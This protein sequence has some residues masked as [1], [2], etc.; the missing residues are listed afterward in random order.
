M[1]KRKVVSGK[2]LY[3]KLKNDYN[4]LNL[5]FKRLQFENEKMKDYTE[6]LKKEIECKNRN[7]LQEQLKCNK[8]TKELD[9]KNNKLHEEQFKNNN[10]ELKIKNLSQEVI[11]LQKNINDNLLVKK[12][13]NP[14][15]PNDEK[16]IPNLSKSKITHFEINGNQYYGQMPWTTMLSY[17]IKEFRDKKRQRI[18]NYFKI[19]KHRE[20]F[21]NEITNIKKYQYFP[22]Y[23]FYACIKKNTAQQ[24]FNILKNV[25]KDKKFKLDIEIVLS[26]GEVFNYQNL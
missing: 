26:S 14:K 6:E 20:Y 12:P 19:I 8:L 23:E 13:K 9:N 2:S 25:C 18:N 24:A 16:D 11:D 17:L 1:S 5:E 10:L 22:E 7:L 15:K 3:D 21:K 4:R